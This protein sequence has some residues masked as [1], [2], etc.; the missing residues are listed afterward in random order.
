M[1]K[2]SDRAARY[3]KRV[4][5]KDLISIYRADCFSQTARVQP[6]EW[7]H[8]QKSLDAAAVLSQE[9]RKIERP[10][11]L[12][13]PTDRIHPAQLFRALLSKPRPVGQFPTTVPVSI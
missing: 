5:E 8:D 2:R 7:M 11:S 4:Y 10:T 13:C 1:I 3:L 9:H 6:P 12:Y